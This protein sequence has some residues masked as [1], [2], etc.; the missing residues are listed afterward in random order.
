[1]KTVIIVLGVVLVVYGVIGGCKEKDAEE[2]KRGTVPPESIPQGKETTGLEDIDPN[3]ML[4]VECKDPNCEVE[5]Q[6]GKRAYWQD[7]Q[8]HINPMSLVAPPVACKKCGKESIYRAEKCVNPSCGIVFIKGTVPN[9]FGDR[10]PECGC[11]G[12]EESRKRRWIQQ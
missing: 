5:Y 9:D 2:R 4:W 1:M 11:S 3:E 10:C 7:V 8:E 12:T 6:T